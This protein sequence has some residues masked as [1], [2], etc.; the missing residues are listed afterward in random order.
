MN[1]LLPL[2][3]MLLTLTTAGCRS[4]PSE[5]SNQASLQQAV[6][7]GSI[8]DIKN[9]IKHGASLNEAIGC[10]NFLPLEGA[11]VINDITK[12]EFMLNNNASANQRCISAAQKSQNTEF[13]RLLENRLAGNEP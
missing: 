1:K 2:F 10:G 6:F 5:T 4:L 12:F 13:L 9:A 11:V 3:L 7:Y 8:T